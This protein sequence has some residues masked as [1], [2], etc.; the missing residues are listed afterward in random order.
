[1]PSWKARCSAPA[2]GCGSRPSSS[3]RPTTGTSGPRATNASLSD[4]LAL[5]GALAHAIASEIK[6]R[7]TAQEQ[8]GLTSR[9]P[10]NPKAYLAYVR[11]RYFWNKRTQE[12]LKTAIGYFQEALEADPAYAPAYSGLADCQFYLGYAFGRAPPREAMP[13]A[14]AAALKALDLDETLAEAHTSLAL[15]RFFYDWD[16]SGAESEFRRAIEL[17]PNYAT[18]HHGY[19]A[20]LAVM[21]RSE[22]SVTEA[23]RGLETD[24]LSLPVNNMVGLVLNAAGRYDEAIEQWRKMLE[25]DPSS[26]QAVSGLAKAYEGKGL[27]NLAIEQYLSLAALSRQSQRN[28]QEL[29]RSYD[30][31]G[32]R[33]FREEKARARVA[34]KWDGWH[35]SA[36]EI[37][38]AYALLG[39]RD[40]AMQYLERAYEARSGSLAWIEINYRWPEAMRSD[41]RFQDLLRRIGLPR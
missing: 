7:L 16:W 11:G 39:Q 32:M 6:G 4:I 17:N 27:E 38:A 36:P 37:A 12:S 40:E 26:G 22:E 9:P 1:M 2:T 19:A 18:A 29:R 30:R 41:P 14:K 25:M 31:G 24:P 20:L 5:Q 13:K 21:H 8:A 35:W 28:V 10:V 15:V 3:G 33:G 23:R 34:A